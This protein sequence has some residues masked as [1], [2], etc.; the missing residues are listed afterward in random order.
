LRRIERTL[1]GDL[2]V[3]SK[4]GITP[5]LFGQRLIPKLAH[6]VLHADDV[7]AE[8][9]SGKSDVLRFGNAEWTPTALH[10]ALQK[11]LPDLQIQTATMGPH[12]EVEAVYTGSL[13]AALVPILKGA[14]PARLSEPVLASKVVTREPVWLALPSGHPLA[15]RDTASLADLARL[16]WVRRSHGDWFHPAEQRMFNELKDFDPAV[17]HHVSGHVEA[18]S[19]VREAGA[20]CL[21]PPGGAAADVSLAAIADAPVIEFALVWRRGAVHAQTLRRLVETIREYHYDWARSIPRYW[22]FMSE[23]PRDFPGF[24]RYARS[25]GHLGPAG[26]D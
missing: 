8:A 16:T 21:V 10:E 15:Q 2:F 20:A 7:L 1:G 6:L 19:W 13:T 9:L 12:D 14:A 5:T 26:L 3:R 24:T 22:S 18:M 25:V 17:L 23:H 4:N 11:S